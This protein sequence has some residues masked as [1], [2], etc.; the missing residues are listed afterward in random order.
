MP[1]HRSCHVRTLH[2]RRHLSPS[3]HH[4][5]LYSINVCCLAK[6][7]LRVPVLQKGPDWT[8]KRGSGD[9]QPPRSS[10]ELRELV[11]CISS[12]LGI[13]RRLDQVLS[14][15]ASSMYA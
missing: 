6:C 10:V 4:S 14:S 9:L 7:N 5:S 13:S 2:C 12:D 3:R 15:C 8:Q 11:L 1:Q